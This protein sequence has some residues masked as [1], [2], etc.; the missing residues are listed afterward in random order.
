[1][2]LLRTP[3]TAP[4]YVKAPSRY[5]RANCRELA[6]LAGVI[7]KVENCVT[8]GVRR[9]GDADVHLAG[10]AS[11]R[12]TDPHSVAYQGSAATFG[13]LAVAGADTPETTS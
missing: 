2:A 1:M 4:G 13:L 11:A 5:A 12:C 9:A 10:W 3:R 8:L 7:G 6:E